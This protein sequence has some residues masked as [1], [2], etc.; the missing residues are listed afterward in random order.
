[1]ENGQRAVK[2]IQHAGIYGLGPADGCLCTNFEIQGI[3]VDI[4]CRKS[5]GS[6][7]FFGTIARVH[8]HHGDVGTADLY[9]VAEEVVRQL[10]EQTEHIKVR[11]CDYE[12][13]KE[14]RCVSC[15]KPRPDPNGYQCVECASKNDWW[16]EMPDYAVLAGKFNAA[17]ADHP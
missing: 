16:F 7:D 2:L 1:M 5:S 10:S 8:S 3:S 15:H 14:R 12:D 4:S 13:D 11:F 6:L 17:S 9:L